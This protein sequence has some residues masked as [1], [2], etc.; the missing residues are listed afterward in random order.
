MTILYGEFNEGGDIK[1]NYNGPIVRPQTEADAIFIEV[2]VG[3]T[4]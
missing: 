4:Q 2:T 3:C 1:M